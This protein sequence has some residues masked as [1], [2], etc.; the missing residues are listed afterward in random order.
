MKMRDR[1]ETLERSIGVGYTMAEFMRFAKIT[2]KAMVLNGAGFAYHPD[3]D[4]G[5]DAN[6]EITED[7]MAFMRRVYPLITGKKWPEDES[8][9]SAGTGTQSRNQQEATPHQKG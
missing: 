5:E 3:I 2:W 4:D 7:D 6:V 9:G 1:V 8:D